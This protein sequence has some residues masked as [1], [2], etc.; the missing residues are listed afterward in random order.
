[1]TNYVVQGEYTSLPG[2]F[3]HAAG[4]IASHGPYKTVADIYK[5]P[6]LTDHDRQMF[7]K[8]EHLFAVNPPGR[9]TFDE[10]LNARVST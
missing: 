6:N 5:I 7:K 9:R 2:M 4:K 10:R 3:P 8:Y 1:M